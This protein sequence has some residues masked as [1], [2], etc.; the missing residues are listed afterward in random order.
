MYG[1][2]V[3]D[4]FACCPGLCVPVLAQPLRSLRESTRDQRPCST[5]IQGPALSISARQMGWCAARRWHGERLAC[6]YCFVWVAHQ[7]ISATQT[8]HRH[9]FSL[10][11]SV[12]VASGFWPKEWPSRMFIM[13]LWHRR[14]RGRLLIRNLARLLSKYLLFEQ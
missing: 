2:L 11:V 8:Y 14:V 9:T 3:L 1:V 7:L 5:N 6:R 12:L 10:F 13:H 4:G